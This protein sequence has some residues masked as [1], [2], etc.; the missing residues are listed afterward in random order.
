LASRG[1][2]QMGHASA[3]LGSFILHSSTF[4]SSGSFHHSFT[5]SDFCTSIFRVCI[6][7]ETLL[8]FS[9]LSYTSRRSPL[10][11]LKTLNIHVPLYTKTRRYTGASYYLLRDHAY[12]GD[13]C[14]RYR[15]AAALIH[16]M[17]SPCT[18]VLLLL[19]FSVNP[20]QDL[21][22]WYWCSKIM[23]HML[24]SSRAYWDAYIMMPG[25]IVNF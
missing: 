8:A 16:V 20:E 12:L 9:L 1:V 6:I 21:L 5:L 19:V 17:M 4:R 11:E 2:S 15:M 24:H 23:K 3:T 25:V 22:P 7:S 10:L 18:H 14:H 13:H